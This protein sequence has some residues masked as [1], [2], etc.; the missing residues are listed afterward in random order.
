MEFAEIDLSDWN[1]FYNTLSSVEIK[2]KTCHD[3]Y[4]QKIFD[5]CD[6]LV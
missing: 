4:G 2:K 3:A 1:S 5:G 6:Y